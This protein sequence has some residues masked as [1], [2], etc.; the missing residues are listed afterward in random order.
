[1][2]GRV[3]EP[4]RHV[5]GADLVPAVVHDEIGVGRTGHALDPRR[6]RRLHVERRRHVV[7]VE[8]LA[9]AF[10]RVTHE[11]AADVI[12]VVVRDEGAGD[13]HT[14]GRRDLDELAHAVRGVDGQ[15]VSGFPVADEACEVDHLPG[16]G[17]V[18]GE[19]APG[20]QLAEVQA[21]GHG[22]HTR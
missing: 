3:E 11:V 14:V 12:G 4:D 15:R 22:P 19:V 9:R 18:A 7:H 2:P 16:D 6:L 1:M 17:I 5:A 13:A 21:V 10:D 8:E 20:E